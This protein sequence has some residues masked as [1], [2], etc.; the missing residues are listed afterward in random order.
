MNPEPIS[1]VPEPPQQFD[2]DLAEIDLRFREDENI[3][4][5]LADDLGSSTITQRPADDLRSESTAH[6]SGRLDQRTIGIPNPTPF[7]LQPSLEGVMNQ[8][9]NICRDLMSD[10]TC[11]LDQIYQAL[12][13]LDTIKNFLHT[14]LPARTISSVGSS[15][16]GRES[17][18]CWICDSQTEKTTFRAFGTF[19][20][21]LIGHDIFEF[22]WRCTEGC[23]TILHRRD[24]MRSHLIHRHNKSGLTPADVEATRERYDPPTNC[25]IC[26]HV[27]PSWPVYFDHIKG[28]CLISPGSGNAS[29][30]GD[31]SDRGDNGDRNGG[32][33]N[34]HG[35]GSSSA[36]PSNSNGGSQSNQSNNRTGGTPYPSASFGGFRS[37]NNTL[38]GPISHSA[39]D[40][41]LNSSRRQSATDA[42]EQISIEDLLDSSR[43]SRA[44]L[45]R[46]NGKPNNLR[47]PQNPRLPRADPS[48]K[49]K[50]RDK[51]KEPTE[52]EAPSPNKCRR[53]DHNM[54][55][56]PR[57]KSVLSCH[58]CGDVPRSAI[59]V[60][61]SWTM[62]VQSLTDSS[63]T[64]INLDQSYLNSPEPLANFAMPQNMP[65]QLPSYYASNEMMQFFDSQSFDMTNTFMLDPSLNDPFIRMATV[66]GSH[67]SL[68][69]IG[70]K[71]QESPM[72]ECDTR[73]LR[74]IGLSTLIDPLSVKR[75]TEQAKAKPSGGPAPG[76][77]TDLVFRNNGSS[78]IPEAPQLVF[79]CQCPCVTL[80]SVDYEAHTSFQLSANDRVEMTF[81]MS[82]ARESSH[83][84]R[85]RVRVFVKLFS[86]RAS[87][88]K[89]NTKKQRTHSITSETTGEDAESDT[90]SEQELTPTSHS[91]SEITP[92]LYWTEDEDVQDWSFSF[93]IKSAIL[94]LAQWTSGIDADTCQK[95]LLSDPGHILDLISMY[96]VYKFKIS[97]LL[98][99]RNCLSLFLS[100]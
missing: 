41:Q 75:Q 26:L 99:G 51:Q 13:H 80:P 34:G 62:P 19:K 63:S 11:S 90:D 8:V 33:G 84:L 10:Q 94:K 14:K 7:S 72:F 50:R 98:M 45:P 23:N 32:N 6:P 69:D 73:L 68:S 16:K 37:R 100:I 59:Q 77:Y 83:P 78:P 46:G 24:R 82:P 54:A 39:S 76:S 89:S 21:H 81:K 12:Q 97:W 44:H 2:S 65:T 66:D 55:K 70:D 95:L 36:G 18:R 9:F 91:G 86:L 25:P 20:R 47:P 79:T 60:G 22:E 29:I 17:Y 61:A 93:D 38:P 49:R 40:G 4:Q 87:A 43:G 67:P 48:F 5:T 96:V 64:I 92:L 85:T 57:C 30:K 74:T 31:R 27:T 42:I 88:A 3:P 58:K 28:H 52:E 56:C 53:C 35:H 1:Q 71:I 15:E